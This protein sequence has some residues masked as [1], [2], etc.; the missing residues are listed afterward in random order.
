MFKKRF[1]SSSIGACNMLLK[2]PFQGLQIFPWKFLNRTPYVGI[3]ILQSSRIYNFGFLTFPFQ[4]PMNLCHFNVVHVTEYKL[5]YM[6]SKWWPL[7][8]WAM[9]NHVNMCWTCDFI[10]ATFWLQFALTT[11]KFFGLCKSI[12]LWIL[13][14]NVMVPCQS[15]CAQFLC[16]S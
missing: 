6:E 8:V 15:S 14:F 5:Y 10:H 11:L 2:N 16:K 12:S 4:S 9:I 13:L 7:K 3:T 1:I